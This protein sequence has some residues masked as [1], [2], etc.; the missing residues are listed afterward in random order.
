MI[1]I[2]AEEDQFF[3]QGVKRAFGAQGI[4]LV[5]TTNAEDVADL[6]ME[7]EPV[8]VLL[9]LRLSKL[10]GFELL[11]ALKEDPR[12]KNVPL[13]V[14]SQLAS[15][16][17]IQRCFS[18]GACE[19]F[20]KGQHHPHEVARHVAKRF[21]EGEENGFTLPE[22]LG[23]CVVF[24][25]AVGFTF[26]QVQ[27]VL[28]VR[29]DDGQLAMMRA[30]VSAMVAA[31]QERAVLVGCTEP[32]DRAVQLQACRLCKEESCETSLPT[33]WHWTGAKPD[34]ERYTL[35][36]DPEH[37]CTMASMV[38]CHVAIEPDGVQP[39]STSAFKLRFFLARDRDGLEGGRTH[40]INQAGVME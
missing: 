11:Q 34:Y 35:V 7:H 26:L 22:W 1:V 15:Q 3:A 19:Y 20:L 36:L 14:W 23:V 13:M 2:Y 25:V 17:D 5:H 39:I 37:I 27:R 10:N 16:E 18:L 21:E 33:P 32:G 6:M 28:D 12:T 31:Q 29:R 30:S 38:P 8:A 40:T 4:D 24:L 9:D